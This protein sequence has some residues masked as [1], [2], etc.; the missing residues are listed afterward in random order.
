[1]EVGSKLSIKRMRKLHEPKNMDIATTLQDKEKLGFC[2]QWSFLKLFF[3]RLIG[4]YIHS[5]GVFMRVFMVNYEFDLFGN[6]LEHFLF[7]LS[8]CHKSSVKA[9]ILTGWE[10]DETHMKST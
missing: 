9:S 3:T 10:M 7:E 1:M 8:S 6:F 2:T 5:K 4:P